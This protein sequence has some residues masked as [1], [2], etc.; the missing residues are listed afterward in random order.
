M[1]TTSA[2]T[3]AMRALDDLLGF[4]F[5][6]FSWS[7]SFSGCRV[8]LAYGLGGAVTLTAEETF[9]LADKAQLLGHWHAEMLTSVASEALRRPRG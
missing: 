7:I 6:G 9:V 1:N 4:E 2:F 3:R 8:H 5:V